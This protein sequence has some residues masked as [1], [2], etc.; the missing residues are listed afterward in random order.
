MTGLFSA[1]SLPLSASASSSSM[2]SALVS[3][4]R[5]LPSLTGL[6]LAPV[7]PAP[8]RGR[9]GP[10][11]MPP[12]APLWIVGLLLCG[13]LSGDGCSRPIEVTPMSEALPALE[14][15]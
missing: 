2:S 3:R 5:K 6:P 7:V 12:A 14:R 1:C 13:M 15:A 10:P 8:G 4:C 11:P 9:L